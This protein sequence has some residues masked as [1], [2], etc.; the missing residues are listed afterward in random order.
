MWCVPGFGSECNRMAHDWVRGKVKSDQ[1]TKGEIPTSH[2]EFHFHHTTHPPFHQPASK[3]IIPIRI[4]TG[5]RH[6]KDSYQDP[7]LQN[8]WNTTSPRF[9]AA[10]QEFA[11]FHLDLDHQQAQ[12]CQPFITIHHHSSPFITIYLGVHF[13]R[14]HGRQA[15]RK[16]A[17]GNEGQD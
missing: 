3:A 12:K 4:F 8:L 13:S 2:Q 1:H 16:W 5:R 6:R 14:P 10:G 17:V 9:S 15:G 7:Y 11:H